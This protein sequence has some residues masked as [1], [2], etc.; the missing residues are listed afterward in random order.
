MCRVREDR[1]QGRH[2]EREKVCTRRARDGLD[3]LYDMAAFRLFEE[4]DEEGWV[5]SMR[6]W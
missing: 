5:P 6:V 4:E 3:E 1:P 2:G